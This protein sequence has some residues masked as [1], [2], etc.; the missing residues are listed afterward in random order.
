MSPA[1]RAYFLALPDEEFRRSALWLYPMIW[2]WYR[3]RHGNDVVIA[4]LSS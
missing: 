1:A 2:R 4:I 3:D